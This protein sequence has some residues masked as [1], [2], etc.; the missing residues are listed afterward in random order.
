M[1]EH[2]ATVDLTTAHPAQAASAPAPRAGGFPGDWTGNFIWDK[3]E[4]S[5][6]H[7]S[8]LFRRTFPLADLPARAVI[9]IAAADKYRLFVNGHY[10]ARG[11][12]RTVGPQLTPYDT[13]DLGGLLRPGKNVVAVF[14]YHYGCDNAFSVNQRA[15][16]WAELALTA[17]V[18]SPAGETI[19]GTDAGWRVRPFAGYRRDRQL[20]NG[21]DGRFNEILD[22]RK[23]PAD[24][25]AVD[26]DESDRAPATVIDPFTSNCCWSYLEPRMIAPL[27][28]E[29][30]LPQKIVAVDLNVLVPAQDA[31]APEKPLYCET[32]FTLPDTWP[33]KRLWLTSTGASLG[34]LY[35]NN[36]PVEIENSITA[37][38]MTELDISGLVKK[39]GENVL[40]RVAESPIQEL[41][42]VWTEGE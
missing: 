25:M 27:H 23:D 14:A 3:G 17:A 13:H 9:R 10:L 16:L 24:W 15:G 19:I 28:E 6:F 35:I 40:R 29:P 41:N 11:P 34:K 4:R 32:R 21:N 2:Q 37:V 42:L 1:K 18:G 30:L 22:Q 31:K 7:Y 39:D 5:P 20:H 26:F 8:L 36:Y 38:G 33:A 12:A